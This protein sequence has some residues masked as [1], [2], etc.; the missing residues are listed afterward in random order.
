MLF[1]AIRCS[2]SDAEAS[3]LSEA[4]EESLSERRSTR[5]VH[6]SD[7]KLEHDLL[8]TLSSAYGWVVAASM[9]WSGPLQGGHRPNNIVKVR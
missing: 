9:V 7:G 5:L 8:F 6:V 2:T 1:E 4:S 3:D